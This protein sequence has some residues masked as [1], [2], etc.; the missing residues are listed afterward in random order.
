[1]STAQYYQLHAIPHPPHTHPQPAHFVADRPNQDTN[2]VQHTQPNYENDDGNNQIMPDSLD[3]SLPQR[4]AGVT[5]TAHSPFPEVGAI[6]RPPYTID[7]GESETTGTESEA[8]GMLTEQCHKYDESAVLSQSPLLQQ[9]VATVYTTS[10]PLETSLESQSLRSS[11][12]GG[13]HYQLQHQMSEADRHSPLQDDLETRGRFTSASVTPDSQQKVLVLNRTR[14][15][16]SDSEGDQSGRQELLKPEEDERGGDWNETSANIS[17]RNPMDQPNNGMENP[18][19]DIR[20]S[21]EHI[22]TLDEDKDG[23]RDDGVCVQNR[24][25]ETDSSSSEC[26]NND[27][28]IFQVT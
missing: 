22:H 11:T 7:D 5:T 14:Q 24:E 20:D 1:M 6:R 26:D 23:T 21:R 4:P 19:N 17:D 13:V 25:S 3:D 16:E 12:P 18:I 2:F 15:A 27:K 28:V 9:Q 10:D 8:D